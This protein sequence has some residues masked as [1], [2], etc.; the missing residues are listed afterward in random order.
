MAWISSA[1]D[2][3]SSCTGTAAQRVGLGVE[4]RMAQ[5]GGRAP[6]RKLDCH[7]GTSLAGVKECLKEQ[8]LFSVFISYSSQEALSFCLLDSPSRSLPS[9]L[10]SE[11]GNSSLF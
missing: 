11:Y 5:W 4:G 9:L 1:L 2:Q 6:Q 8:A 7:T 3:R 10:G